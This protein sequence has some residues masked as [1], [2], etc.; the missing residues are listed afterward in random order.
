MHDAV[1][2]LDPEVEVIERL[3]TIKFY[4]A[5]RVAPQPD[6]TGR[7]C[8]CLSKKWYENRARLTNRGLETSPG[9]AV[10]CDSTM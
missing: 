8:A 7:R 2:K 10:I 6:R 5:P 1:R 4:F 9:L 3:N